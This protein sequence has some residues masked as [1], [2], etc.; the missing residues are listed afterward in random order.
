MFEVDGDPG[1]D[2][3]GDTQV[4]TFTPTNRQASVTFTARDDDEPED[5]ERF[6]LKIH[7]ISQGLYLGSPTSCTVYITAND[8][9]YGVFG[10][11]DVSHACLDS[12]LF[13]FREWEFRH[14]LHHSQR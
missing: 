9:A 2:F 10:F 5:K 14:S 12:E 1:D 6:T 13:F 7:F 3:I 8:D 4:A 11:I